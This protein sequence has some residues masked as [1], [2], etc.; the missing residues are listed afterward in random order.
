MF[1]RTYHNI[2]HTTTNKTP[3]ELT[4][5]Q[6]P[7]TRLALTSPNINTRVKLQLQSN[8][9]QPQAETR[10]FSV[11]DPVL[12]RD[13]RPGQHPKWLKGKVTAVL[14]GPRYKLM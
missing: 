3:A 9:K 5:K 7:H 12:V 4:L 14:G 8:T 6:L 13:L 2:S 11:D 10:K 1:L